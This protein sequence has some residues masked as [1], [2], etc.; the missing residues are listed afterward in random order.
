MFEKRRKA[1]AK[2]RRRA[3]RGLSARHLSIVIRCAR[4]RAAAHLLSLMRCADALVVSH[5]GSQYC[6]GRVGCAFDLYA[7]PAADE[8]RR[9]PT[10]RNSTASTTRL[11]LNLDLP[12][13][14][15]KEGM[16]VESSDPSSWRRRVPSIAKEWAKQA[17]IVI[18][19]SLFV[20]LCARVT[21]P[22]PVT[23]V[24]LTLQNFGVLAVGLLLGSRRG[25]AALALYLVEGAFGLPV[26]SPWVGGIAHIFGPTGG[27]LMAYPLVAFVAGWIYE[28]SF[29]PFRLGCAVSR[30][31][32]IRALRGWLSWLAVLTHSVSLAIKYGLYWFVFAEVIKVLMAA[33]VAARWQQSGLGYL[34]TGLAR[35]HYLDGQEMRP[36]EQFLDSS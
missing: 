2:R 19:A 24:P 34:E 29:A 23:P 20:A 11:R 9:R 22:L 17:A 8:A 5:P 7:G 3:D 4:I 32:G 33:G 6:S 28:Q 1:M 35:R 18:A 21:V 15:Q 31:C 10:K 26:F 14:P 16:H 25:F 12:P 30:G 27:F 13:S 36:A